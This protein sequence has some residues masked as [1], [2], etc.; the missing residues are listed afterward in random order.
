VLQLFGRLQY[1]REWELYHDRPDGAS[2]YN[3]RGSGLQHLSNLPMVQIEAC[4]DS[5]KGNPNST[6][7]ASIHLEPLSQAMA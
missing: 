1:H 4:G 2:K 7:R 5:R 3:E 6:Q